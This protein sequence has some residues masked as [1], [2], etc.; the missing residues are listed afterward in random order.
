MAK[1]KATYHDFYCI[2]CG[3]RGLPLPRKICMQH[4]KFHR[5]RMYCPWCKIE[6]AHVEVRTPEEAQEFIDLYEEGSFTEEAAES[7]KHCA[8]H[9][10]SY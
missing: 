4:E 9:Q 10:R 5:K 6:V 1:T 2:N 8:E 7:I 3:K